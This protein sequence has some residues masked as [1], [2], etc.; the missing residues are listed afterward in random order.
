MATTG[1]PVACPVVRRSERIHLPIDRDAARVLVRTAL[2]L[3]GDGRGLLAGSAQSTVTTHVT[4]HVGATTERGGAVG[5]GGSDVE[6]VAENTTH[7][8]FFYWFFAV[9]FRFEL[10]RG[11]RWSRTAIW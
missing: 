8:P 5:R 6:V 1:R 11:L 9:I 2:A 4:A 10:R 7:L 3:D